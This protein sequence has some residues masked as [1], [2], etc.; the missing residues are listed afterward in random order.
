MKCT[1]LAIPIAVFMIFNFQSLFYEMPDICDKSG[2]FPNNYFQF[3]ITLLM[4]RRKDWNFYLGRNLRSYLKKRLS[5]DVLVSSPVLAQVSISQT[6]SLLLCKSSTAQKKELDLS[7]CTFQPYVF[8]SK[9]TCSP[10]NSGWAEHG[11]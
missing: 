3:S 5:A 11:I 2:V 1:L 6:S 9:L 8:S 10:V 4:S 7:H